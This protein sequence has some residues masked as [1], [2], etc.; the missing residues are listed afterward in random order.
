MSKVTNKEVKNWIKWRNKIGKTDQVE[1]I[2]ERFVENSDKR[3][4]RFKRAY[5]SAV[6][7][8]EQRHTLKMMSK[9]ARRVGVDV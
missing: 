2:T 9:M 8:R 7:E 3:W 6:T 4:E 1:N 5:N